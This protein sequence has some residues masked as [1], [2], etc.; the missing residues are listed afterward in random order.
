MNTLTQI[1]P[2]NNALIAALEANRKRAVEAYNP[3]P[4]ECLEHAHTAYLYVLNNYMAE[5]DRDR[6]QKY[7]A[8]L[9]AAG[10]FFEFVRLYVKDLKIKERH[11][12][13]MFGH[14]NWDEMK[15]EVKRRMLKAV[16]MDREDRQQAL[17]EVK[18][19]FDT[20]FKIAGGISDEDFLKFEE[21]ADER[22]SFPLD[23]IDTHI[24]PDIERNEKSRMTPSEIVKYLIARSKG[25]IADYDKTNIGRELQRRGFEKAKGGYYVKLVR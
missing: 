17:R 15:P 8:H 5:A 6:F 18:R 20:Q 11:L 21:M 1:K 9:T 22:I 2:K 13:D 23:K 4:D 24:L 7:N 10:P 16:E 12:R 25:T 19:V 14:K 3:S